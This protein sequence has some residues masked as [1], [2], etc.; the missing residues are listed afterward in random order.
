M[1]GRILNARHETVQMFDAT[2]RCGQDMCDDCGACLACS[3]P[4]ECKHAA[5]H[6]WLGYLGDD[7][8]IAYIDKESESA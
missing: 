1:F 5:G 8:L 7:D 6:I 3:C 2:P 4:D